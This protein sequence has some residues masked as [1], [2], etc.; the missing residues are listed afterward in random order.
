MN[1]ATLVMVLVMATAFVAVIW[2]RDKYDWPSDYQLLIMGV[3][4]TTFG[5]LMFFKCGGW[6]CRLGG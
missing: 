1:T 4:F 2:C 6:V 5:A 3:V